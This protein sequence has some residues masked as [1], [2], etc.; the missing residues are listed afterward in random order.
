VLTLGIEHFGV[1]DRYGFRQMLKGGP[2]CCA[3]ALD[4]LV[5]IVVASLSRPLRR[6]QLGAAG[7]HRR[8]PSER[9]DRYALL[10]CCI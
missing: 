4:L 1:D 2:L 7:L 9:V 3:A 6:L 5:L 10:G 8:K